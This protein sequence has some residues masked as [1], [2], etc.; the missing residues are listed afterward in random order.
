MSPWILPRPTASGLRYEVRFRLGGRGPQLYGGRFR[1]RR[2][3]EARARWIDGE[4]AAM[5]VPDVKA[6][7]D[8]PPSRPLS[9]W[10]KA[11][12]DS[13]IDVGPATRE[14]Y[15]KHMAR[16]DALGKMDA[17]AITPAD[18]QRWIGTLGDLKASSVKRYVTTLRQVLDYAGADPNPARD[19]RVRLPK[20]E[21]VEV[22]P[23]TAAE[24]DAILANVREQWRL[25]IRVLE[26]TAMRVGEMC[27]LTWADVDFTGSRFRV[28]T[29]KTAAARRWVQIPEPVMEAISER[30]P[31]DDRVPD[32]RVFQMTGQDLRQAMGRACVSA[33]IT[34]YSPH[35][36]RHRRV[37]VWHREGVPFREIAERVGHSR[38]SLTAD[39][40]TH[41][42][43]SEGDA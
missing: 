35:D 16:W 30:T 32:R 39:T 37:S 5:R 3:A 6:L 26:Q 36:L 24:V 33:G 2:D 13:R 12:A 27:S 7:R 17:L 18:V 19:D 23:P 11:W 4:L 14:N 21:R 25:P 40:Y 43:L 15:R 31:P 28:R 10:G 8:T 20:V 9:E 34:R 29:G 41:V 38:T 42:L 22:D 1:R